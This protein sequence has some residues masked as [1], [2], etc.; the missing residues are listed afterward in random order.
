MKRIIN[1][2]LVLSL[3]TVILPTYTAFAD[4][5]TNKLYNYGDAD[6]EINISGETVA[7]TTDGTDIWQVSD[8]GSF[9]CTDTYDFLY[10]DCSIASVSAEVR[11][12][13]LV[14]GEGDGAGA[15]GIMMRAGLE[16]DDPTVFFR[17][18]QGGASGVTY[19]DKKGSTTKWKPIGT[20]AA[21]C[22]I[23][24]TRQGDNFMAAV[25]KEKEWET[26][27]IVNSEMGEKIYVGVAG[28]SHSADSYL[29][30]TF[31]DIQSGSEGSY[32]PSIFSG[33]EETET[34]TPDMLLREN[35]GDGSLIDG[36]ESVLNPI[37]QGAP[38][39]YL[40]ERDEND[41]LWILRNGAVGAMSV[42]KPWTDYEATVNA[43]FKG[44]L[45]A[46][47]LELRVR[48]NNN[49]WFDDRFYGVSLNSGNKLTLRKGASQNKGSIIFET[50]A[51]KEIPDYRTGEEIELKVRAFDNCI[52]AY[53]NGE[54]ILTYADLKRPFLTG[55][56]SVYV[57]TAN[58]ALRRVT[59]N[60]LQ[61]K[62][63]EDYDNFLGGGFNLNTGF[64]KLIYDRQ[65]NLYT[66][67]L[68]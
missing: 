55:G 22:K 37:W 63:G 28:F 45:D 20:L 60:K 10:G 48:A 68:K 57:E 59:V 58:V 41:D 29:K 23:K 66:E 32:D 49:V 54:E 1:A 36:D 50:L 14:K 40:T 56:V 19:R 3:L 25:Y 44:H 34:P 43:K 39:Y 5:G 9:Y 67:G 30:G 27:A 2:I 4:D 61:D 17:I 16:A 53:L 64:L 24:L 46:D 38:K 18:G 21:P 62:L 6:G 33:Y 26:V 65:T 47:K 8:N 11:Q 52:T 35:F 51:E 7:L 42:Y 12:I 13:Q 31:S 15:F